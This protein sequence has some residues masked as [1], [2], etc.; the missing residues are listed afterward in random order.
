VSCQVLRTAPPPVRE[1][2]A[3]EERFYALY[4]WCLNP[5][6][7][8]GDLR[9]RLRDELD[10]YESL[11]AEWQREES[12]INVYLFACAIACTVDDYLA[13]HWWTWQR[14]HGPARAGR[15]L[16][17]VLRSIDAIDWAWRL[18]VDRPIVRWRQQWEHGVDGACALLIGA[19]GPDPAGWLALRATMRPLLATALPGRLLNRR[20]RLPDGFRGQDL[21][22]H[23]A[24]VLARRFA[25]SAGERDRPTAVIGV[26]TT[27]AYF[28][29]LVKAYLAAHGW[30][31]LSSLTLRPRAGLSPREWQQLRRLGDQDARVVLVDDHPDTGLTFA[32]LLD[33]VAGAGVDWRR[34]TILAPRH[35]A[36]PD[37]T[38]PGR[39]TAQGVRLITLEPMELYKVRLLV[40]GAM[41]R[42]LRRSYPDYGDVR[43]E[44]DD[45]VEATN[46]RLWQHHEDGFHVRLKRLFKLEVG[47]DGAEP[48]VTHVIA[49]SVGWG[50]LG[51]HAVLMGTRLAGHVPRVLGLRH[52]LLLTEWIESVRPGAAPARPVVETVATYVAARA[53]HLRIGED[54]GF[55]AAG[56][57]WTGWDEIVH[58]LRG[59]YGAWI[60][61]LKTP[62]LRRRLR[63]LLSPVP[64][65]TDGQM[66]AQEWIEA[67][68]RT[69]KVDFEQHNFGGPEFDLVDPAYDLAAAIWE[70]SLSEDE[71]ARMLDVYARASG[72]RGIRDRMLLYELLHGVLALRRAEHSAARERRRDRREEWNRRCLRARD[73][74]L[75]RAARLHPT[76][77][78]P[79]RWSKRLVFLDLEGLLEAPALGFRHTTPSGVAALELLRAHDFSVVLN[80]AR[81]VDHVRS[82][83]RA[84]GL[85]GGLAE[86]GSVFVD[87]VGDRNLGFTDG[88]GAAQLAQCRQALRDRPGVCLD[89]GYRHSIRAYRYTAHGPT[90][91]DRDEVREVIARCGAD[92][93]T[94]VLGPD[95]TGIIQE[96]TGKAAGARAVRRYL[97]APEEPITAIGSSEEDLEL[98]EMADAAYAPANCARRLRELARRGRCRVMRQPFQHGLLAAA[99]EIVG[100]GRARTCAPG[101]DLPPLGASGELIQA[102]LRA[103]ERPRYRQWLSVLDWRSL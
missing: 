58:M 22:H 76:V 19:A 101:P 55:A 64:S 9:H 42:L 75:R 44:H 73:E 37:W 79:P 66:R 80:T 20:M 62:A 17:V 13:R 59:P 48:P 50:W 54:P 86:H 89:P 28:A 81:S 29:P 61:R 72:D 4:D 85:P 91:L 40:P 18:L 68:T 95:G 102:V 93:L 1:R 53:R 52:G 77:A 60:G 70:F 51:Y 32:L 94:F 27:G 65:V 12:R 43:V 74:L 30:A 6:L 49:K 82:Y 83:C 63:G 56:Y 10:R 71:A 25:T 97:D 92:R 96:G 103:A 15:A 36:R 78:S 26:R 100:A 57:Q 41:E 31:D 5:I 7:P 21:T 2:G 46:A 33:A 24:L 69:Y 14:S 8:L 88:A 39:Y 90:G 38:L 47:S 11:G 84:Y 67:P 16:E 23:D 3:R 35:A 99:K 98:L 87:A 34:I 45:L